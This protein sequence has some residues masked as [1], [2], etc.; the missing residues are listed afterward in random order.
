M[1]DGEKL[2]ATQ[3]QNPGHKQ[4]TSDCKIGHTPIIIE[5]VLVLVQFYLENFVMKNL[6]QT[7][8]FT[9]S[10]L[11]L[12]ARVLAAPPPTRINYCSNTFIQE[13]TTRFDDEA[14]AEA[15]VVLTN[16]VVLFF[17]VKIDEVPAL[18]TALPGDKVKLCL[19]QVPDDCPP[20]FAI[21]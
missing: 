1:P 16:G 19:T 3:G 15:V 7:I 17:Y 14:D 6:Q 9:L 18:K 12:T 5:K 2:L 20:G 4:N 8:R 13:R 21:S 10:Y 11:L